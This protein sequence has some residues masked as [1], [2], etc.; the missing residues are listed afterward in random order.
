MNFSWVKPL[1]RRSKDAIV[2]NAPG[3]LMGIGTV[4]E[5]TSV[6]FAVKVTPAAWN[7]K[8]DAIVDKTAKRDGTAPNET[9]WLI[10]TGKI[11][12]A[13]LTIPETI[14]ACGK[15]YIPA[16]GLQILALLSFWS[17]HGIDVKRQAV[18]AGLYSTAQEK[19][20]EYQRKVREMIG[21]KAERE[22]GKAIAQDKIDANPPPT[23][24]NYFMDENDELWWSIYDHRFKSTLNKVKAAMND[25]NWEMLQ[26]LYI[27]RSELYFFLDP[28]KKYIHPSYEDDHVGWN[29]DKLL[30]LDY[31]WATDPATSKPIGVIK[32]RDKDGFDY[33]PSPGFS[34]SVM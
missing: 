13:K 3:I 31:D 15:Y 1:I 30:V 2:R 27:S 22:V 23:T 11:E 14:K 18:L 10:T 6:I 19:L 17:A 25:A 7:S 32:C 20:V 8:A 21:E 24:N 26:H 28:E 34:K 5:V 33:D 12:A 9:E 16:A 29:V 4:S